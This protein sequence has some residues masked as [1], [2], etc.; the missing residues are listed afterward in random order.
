MGFD[1]DF[2]CQALTHF[3]SARKGG[4]G[5]E[6]QVLR[7][8]YCRRR[9][10]R[11]RRAGPDPSAE[12]RPSSLALAAGGFGAQGPKANVAPRAR[13]RSHCEARPLIAT[14][15]GQGQLQRRQ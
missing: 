13:A 2:L 15:C 9:R 4:C 12:C 7:Q 1:D 8:L 11:R 3:P 10:R 6:Q 14:G 5:D